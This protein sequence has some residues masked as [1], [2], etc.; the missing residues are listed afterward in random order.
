MSIDNESKQ[1]NSL[2]TSSSELSAVAIKV[3]TFWNDKPELWFAQLESQFTLAKITV[4][5][6]KFHYVVASLN[7]E[8]LSCISDLILNPPE[9]DSYR[10]IKERLISQNADSESLRLKKLLSE[11][12]LGD[13]KPS[14]LLYEMKNLAPGKISNDL[15]KNLWMQRLPLQTQQI[16]SISND[17]LESLSKMADSITEIS[18]DSSIASVSACSNSSELEL[19]HK[20]IRNI[21]QRLSKIEGRTRS[22]SR[23]RNVNIQSSN[24]INLCW[25]HH[26][27]GDKANK[28]VKPCNYESEN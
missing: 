2:N 18:R 28:C 6:T 22:R 23:G 19:V 26:K 24:K 9:T 20:R 17:N 13:K 11:I 25:F 15:L 7:S 10:A 14:K 27:F 4:D 16:L 1:L 8:D 21:E 12:E 5:S 3:P